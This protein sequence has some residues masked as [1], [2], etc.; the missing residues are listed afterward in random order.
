M[1]LLWGACPGP[2]VLL[3]PADELSGCSDAEEEQA[4]GWLQA[5]QVSV[6]CFSCRS[7]DLQTL[8]GAVPS[9]SR[10]WGEQGS[11]AGSGKVLV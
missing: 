2:Q 6:S 3:K 9:S 4:G 8:T 5:G 10:G 1:V 7:V 11:A